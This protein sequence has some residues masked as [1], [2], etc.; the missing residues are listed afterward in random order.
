MTSSEIIVQLRGQISGDYIF[1]G[2][3]DDFCKFMEE[4]YSKKSF[5]LV[6]NITNQEIYSNS[7]FISLL[8]KDNKCETEIYLNKFNLD[9]MKEK[10]LLNYNQYFL[11]V[12][13][14][15]E[16]NIYH[17]SLHDLYFIKKNFEY[18]NNI[19]YMI[20]YNNGII[21]DETGTFLPEFLYELDLGEHFD[22][23]LGNENCSYLPET[24]NTL[25]IG[26]SFSLPINNNYG[27]LLSK[28]L[29]KLYF[30]GFFNQPIGN[31]NG[32]FLPPLLE[33]L[34]LSDCFNNII[35]IQNETFLPPLLKKLSLGDSF[36]QPIGY[37]KSYLPVSSLTYTLFLGDDFDHPTSNDH[38][39]FLPDN[40][41]FGNDVDN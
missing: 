6:N 33:E 31:E 29:K 1:N 14:R 24:L 38:E 17:I 13:I 8:N 27:S 9:N 10:I 40:V 12:S 39:L 2:N 26:W 34:Y 37:M 20:A 16:Y 15:I 18:Y 32:S 11:D 30:D 3:I 22:N 23:P 36:N 41:V 25:T 21:G 7:I 5:V 28:S 35:G 4:N 19:L